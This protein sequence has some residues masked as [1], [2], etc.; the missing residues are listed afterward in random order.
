MRK[1]WD[2]IRV[3]EELRS[4]NHISFF[5]LFLDKVLHIEILESN[6]NKSKF[7]SKNPE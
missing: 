4:T 3:S 2:A 5:H 1:M 7:S 6:P